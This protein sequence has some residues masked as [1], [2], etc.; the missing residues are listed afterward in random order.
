MIEPIFGTGAFACTSGAA[1]VYNHTSAGSGLKVFVH[2]CETCGTKTHLTFERWP[3]IVGVYAGTFDDP[4]WFDI[5]P[6]TS[7]YIFRDSAQRGTLIPSGFP[8]YG[9][10]ATTN[11]GTPI[12]PVV[13]SNDLHIR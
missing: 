8:V 13:L 3:D 5:V 2:F 11:D 12:E 10:H 6:E 1:R 4:N 7:K 9:Q